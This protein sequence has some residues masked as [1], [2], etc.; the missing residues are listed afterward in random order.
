[1][2]HSDF[3][4]VIE[5]ADIADSQPQDFDFRQLFVRRQRGQI[6]AQAGEGGVERFDSNSLPTS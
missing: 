2:T 1:M 6:L 5:I 3:E 4:D